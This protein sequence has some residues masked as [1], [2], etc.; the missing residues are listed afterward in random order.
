VGAGISERA[1]LET[2]GENNG[3]QINNASTLKYPGTLALWTLVK[4]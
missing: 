4:T 2:F 3:L 1:A